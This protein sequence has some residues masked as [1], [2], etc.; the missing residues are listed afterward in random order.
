M[1]RGELRGEAGRRALFD[2]RSTQKG[3]PARGALAYYSTPHTA[4]SGWPG[5]GPCIIPPFHNPF[6]SPDSDN[7]KTQRMCAPLTQLIT[8]MLKASR[9]VNLQYRKLPFR[10][11]AIFHLPGT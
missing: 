10:G 6:H 3:P 11:R 4:M 2:R 9:R 5:L 7:K 1:A 8:T